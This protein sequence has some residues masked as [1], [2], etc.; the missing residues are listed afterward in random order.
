[1]IFP[2]LKLSGDSAKEPWGYSD[3]AT[4]P[5]HWFMYYDDESIS[6]YCGWTGNCMFE[7]NYFKRD[8]NHYVIDSLKI[9]NAL[10]EF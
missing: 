7:A 3:K 6:Y 5:N 4:S 9:N 8:I 2:S 10:A 1:M